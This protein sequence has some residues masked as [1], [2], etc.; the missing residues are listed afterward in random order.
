MNT[1]ELCIEEVSEEII[2][3]QII[4]F[5]LK[6][7]M[8]GLL[9]QRAELRQTEVQTMLMDMQERNLMH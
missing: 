9:R 7:V 6:M 4:L 2:F 3:I 8:F 1:L 5:R